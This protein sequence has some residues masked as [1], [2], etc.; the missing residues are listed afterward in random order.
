[1][2]NPL[3]CFPK[4]LHHFKFLPTGHM[5]SSFSTYLPALSSFFFFCNCHPNRRKVIAPRGL[6]CISLTISTFSYTL[7]NLIANDQR[8]ALCCC[9]SSHR[10]P[11]SEPLHKLLLPPP[12]FGVVNSNPSYSSCDAAHIQA[13]L[14]ARCQT[15]QTISVRF[16]A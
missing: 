16:P 6:I 5:C 3:C 9:P 15:L 13:F 1:M 11:I 10:P 4:V 8:F 14:T 7:D 12:S 2:R